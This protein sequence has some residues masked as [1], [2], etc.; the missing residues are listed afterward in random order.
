MSIE[1]ISPAHHASPKQKRP[2]AMYLKHYG[3]S[4]ISLF[5]PFSALSL[6][7]NTGFDFGGIAAFDRFPPI[8]LRSPR[9][10]TSLPDG[11]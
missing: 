6:Q 11:D 3:D 8:E 4:N 9:Q 5:G 7:N 2:R 10:F 1:E